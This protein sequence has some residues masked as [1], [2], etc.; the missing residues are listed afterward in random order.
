MVKSKF[1]ITK[2]LVRLEEEPIS[3]ILPTPKKQHTKLIK[4]KERLSAEIASD[5]KQRLQILAIKK[6]K[7]LTTLIEQA[8]IE[9]VEREQ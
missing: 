8:L 9:Y 6:R 3:V 5:I 4:K 2:E 1:E 7:N